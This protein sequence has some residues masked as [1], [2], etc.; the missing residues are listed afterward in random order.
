VRPR[1]AE[2]VDRRWL[3]ESQHLT[4]FS[5]GRSDFAML[6]N[7]LSRFRG[8]VAIHDIVILVETAQQH[9]SLGSL[10]LTFDIGVFSAAMRFQCQA[11]I[12]P[13]LP[14]GAKPMRRLHERNQQSGPDRT[15]IRNPFE[16]LRRVMLASLRQQIAPCF[17]A[18]LLQSI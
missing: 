9:R 12:R 15:D 10:Q 14:L 2:F 16:Q 1:R 11:A 13:Q 7:R 17:L 4:R 18:Q 8:Q 5:F 3:L 6:T